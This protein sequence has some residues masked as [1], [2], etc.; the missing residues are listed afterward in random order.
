MC[1]SLLPLLRDPP[2]VSD[3]KSL[4]SYLKVFFPPSLLTDRFISTFPPENIS[5]E[6]LETKLEELVHQFGPDVVVVVF[7]SSTNEVFHSPQS[8]RCQ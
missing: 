4:F 2:S 7:A 8:A 5:N 6:S 3:P 1:S